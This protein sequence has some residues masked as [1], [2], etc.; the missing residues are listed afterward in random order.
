M[1]GGPYLDEREEDKAAYV[2]ADGSG[3]SDMEV[4]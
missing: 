2:K 4:T 1:Q 3:I